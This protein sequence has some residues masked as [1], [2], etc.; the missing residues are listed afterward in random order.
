MNFDLIVKPIMKINSKWITDLNIKTI[1]LVG[2]NI[3]EN[4]LI[5]EA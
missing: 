4:H 2:R 3:G 5:P 1:K